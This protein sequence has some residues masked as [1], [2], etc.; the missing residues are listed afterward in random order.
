MHNDTTVY[1][2]LLFCTETQADVTSHLALIIMPC[3]SAVND[4]PPL[5]HCGSITYDYNRV[6]R[7][8]PDDTRAFSQ[9]WTWTTL[10]ISAKRAPVIASETKLESSLRRVLRFTNT[11]NSVPFRI[12]PS[13]FSTGGFSCSLMAP[14]ATFQQGWKGTPPIA[15]L[16]QDGHRRKG[17]SDGEAFVVCLGVCQKA[18]GEHWAHLHSVDK[19]NFKRACDAHACSRDHVS[20]WDEA[21]KLLQLRQ[22]RGTDTPPYREGRPIHRSVTLVFTV[23]PI[24]ENGKTLVMH[25]SYAEYK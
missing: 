21:S 6:V 5:H 13:C 3:P 2:A 19:E 8:R 16:Y 24:N 23:C 22:K 9:P 12:P 4:I 15:L 7:M 20:A 11:T 18:V 25:I 1:L 17:A 14:P 10:Y